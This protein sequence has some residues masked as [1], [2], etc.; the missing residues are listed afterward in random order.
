MTTQKIFRNYNFLLLQKIMEKDQGVIYCGSVIDPR[1]E[2]FDKPVK[3]RKKPTNAN[4]H[5]I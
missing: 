3:D 2:V 1:S 4:R 5:K